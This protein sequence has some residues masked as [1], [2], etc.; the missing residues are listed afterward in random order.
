MGEEMTAGQDG[1]DANVRESGVGHVAAGRLD[2]ARM[3]QAKDEAVGK[4]G[5]VVRLLRDDL[6]ACVLGRSFK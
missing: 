5:L 2:E 1:A 4:L 3:P 6:C